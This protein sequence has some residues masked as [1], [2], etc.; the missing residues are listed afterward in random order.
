MQLS[1]LLLLTGLL[2]SPLPSLAHDYSVGQIHVDHP[3]SRA[4]PPS[5]PNAAAFFILHNRSEVADRLI[6]ASSPLA[7]KTELHEHLHQDGLMKM[8]QVPGVD[9]P[10]GGEVKFV[11]MG[12]HVMLFGVKQQPKDGERFALTLRFEK[13]GEIQV[14]V[15]V[16]QDAPQPAH[17]H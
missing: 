11:P 8:Q 4:M 14:D 17:Q 5:A 13:A 7:Q 15:A 10:A 3:W 16:Q 2:L 9:L 1:K 12:Y 6:S